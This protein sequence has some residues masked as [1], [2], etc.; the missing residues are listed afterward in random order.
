MDD[1]KLNFDESPSA[2]PLLLPILEVSTLLAPEID[3]VP[4]TQDVSLSQEP[5]SDDTVYLDEDELSGSQPLTCISPLETH[6]Q[7][8]ENRRDSGCIPPQQF[9]RQHTTEVRRSVLLTGE[10]D[11]YLTTHDLVRWQALGLTIP[12][13]FTRSSRLIHATMP[14]IDGHTEVLVSFTVD[15]QRGE[16]SSSPFLRPLSFIL[17][18]NKSICDGIG[19]QLEERPANFPPRC[20]IDLDAFRKA[21]LSL[22]QPGTGRVPLSILD[23]V[24]GNPVDIVLFRL[25][26]ALQ[27]L[28][29]RYL[30]EQYLCL[31]DASVKCCVSLYSILR[32]TCISAYSSLPWYKKDQNLSTLQMSL[33]ADA[34]TH[35][36]SYKTSVLRFGPEK[37]LLPEEQVELIG[38]LLAPKVSG[39]I[40]PTSC[41]CPPSPG[42]DTDIPYNHGDYDRSGFVRLNYTGI[43]TYVLRSFMEQIFYADCSQ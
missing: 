34:E 15:R 42:Y 14:G 12:W 5:S 2:D 38:C 18:V 24:C 10:Y 41:I 4:K 32:M 35:V 27:Q 21:C 37:D 36:S 22:R 8:V 1:L 11:N 23:V 29:F 6:V 26:K 19:P 20:K 17:D 25:H 30:K 16:F 7:M 43:P 28:N 39:F 9:L 31:G 40:A 13:L 3:L 33:E